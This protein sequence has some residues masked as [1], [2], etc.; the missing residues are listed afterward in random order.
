MI[1]AASDSGNAAGLAS[2]QPLTC[3]DDAGEHLAIV[4]TNSD[5]NRPASSQPT[6]S[7]LY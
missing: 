3:F 4:N 1:R 6:L 7:A 5:G 2:T